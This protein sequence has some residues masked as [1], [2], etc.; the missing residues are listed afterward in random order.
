[1]QF[2]KLLSTPEAK[3]AHYALAKAYQHLK[4]HEKACHHYAF[5]LKYVRPAHGESYY[6]YGKSL[7]ALK[8]Q[9]SALNNYL[10]GVSHAPDHAPMQ[11]ALARLLFADKQFERAEQH[12]LKTLQLQPEHTEAHLQLWRLYGA[13]D[14]HP[15]TAVHCQAILK[16]RPQDATAMKW[17]K[18]ISVP[19]HS[20]K[21]CRKRRSCGQAYSKP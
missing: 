10:Q 5:V 15:K 3:K 20:S 13:S 8:R 19:R 11:Y 12:Y 6:Q 18:V 1:M 9:R 2:E 17:A 21:Y 16:K 7:E 14:Q 4:N